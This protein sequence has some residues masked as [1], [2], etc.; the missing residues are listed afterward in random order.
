MLLASI[1]SPCDYL[2]A[3]FRSELSFVSIS[4]SDIF[5]IFLIYLT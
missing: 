2:L 3:S 4:V 1:L 5:R